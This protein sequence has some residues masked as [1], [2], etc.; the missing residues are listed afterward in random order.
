MFR[1]MLRGK[2]H[3]ATV[4]DANLEYEGSITIDSHLLKASGILPF[5]KVQVVDINNGQRFETYVIETG[6][7]GTVCVNGAAARLIQPG[8]RVIIMAYGFFG[9]QELHDH[10]PTVVLVDE[11][12]NI[13]DNG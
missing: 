9:D 10:E 7:P 13:R 11:G 1:E 4:T 8:D 12:N 6:R 2:I 3:R 5:E